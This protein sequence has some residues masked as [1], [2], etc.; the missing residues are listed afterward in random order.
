MPAMAKIQISDATTGRT[1][2]GSATMAARRSTSRGNALFTDR[3]GASKAPRPPH[4]RT[5]LA[6]PASSSATPTASSSLAEQALRARDDSEGHQ[7]EDRGVGPGRPDGG[8][9]R[10]HGAD[11][12]AGE[13][14][15][16]QAAESA[17]HDDDER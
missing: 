16:G 9:E 11:E 5:P 3:L 7:H 6:K 10:L 15:A 13:D 4:A 1:A 12:Q 17:Q 14:R 8:H 2:S